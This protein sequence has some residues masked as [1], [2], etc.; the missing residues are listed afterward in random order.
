MGKR[1]DSLWPDK[2]WVPE[3]ATAEQ[4]LALG[5]VDETLLKAYV[6][7]QEWLLLTTLQKDTNVDKRQKSLRKYTANIGSEAKKPWASVIHPALAVCVSAVLGAEVEDDGLNSASAVAAQVG[8]G[9]AGS[10]SAADGSA[11]AAR[12]VK[13]EQKDKKE[14]K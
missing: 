2:Q 14:K 8:V 13:K 12:F 3:L 1:Y 5:E 4:K 10:S 7:K 6:V 9:A 11:S